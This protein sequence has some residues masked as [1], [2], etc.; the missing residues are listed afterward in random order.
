MRVR[1]CDDDE[2]MADGWVAAIKKVTDGYDVERMASA[3]E[4]ISK[5]LLRKMA[6]EKEQDLTEVACGFDDIDILAID[7]DLLHLDDDGSRT[8]GE[9]VA[10][11]ARTFSSCGV[12]VVMNQ[13]KGPQFDLGMRGHLDSH[14][15][16]NVDANLIDRPSLWHDLEP[17][18]GQFNPTT[19]T[20]LP[21]L[22]SAV[23]S[24]A[25]DFE[26]AGLDATVMDLLGLPEEALAEL[27][28]TAFGFVDSEAETTDQLAKVTVRRF[29]S[30][31]L[32]DEALV[33][34]FEA[35]SPK[36]LFSFAAF[37]IAK[38]LERA[39]L[40]PMDV[41]VD[42]LHL[43]DRLP[44]LINPAKI[45]TANPDSWYKAAADPAEFLHWD[46]LAKYRNERASACLGR[47]VFDWYRLAGD[48]Q[49]DQLQDAY[50]ASDA[51]R[52]FLAED[53]SRFVAREALTR[54]RADFHN[55]GDR[56]AVER[57]GNITYGPM[58]RVTFG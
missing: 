53:T 26:K 50:I 34:A 56:R 45:D 57:L 19:W 8:T 49:I 27:S 3:K 22:I 9:G 29:L 52:F 1:V 33:K 6:A 25:A 35:H 48:D 55:F 58:R 38:W 5:L 32:R 18:A 43:V 10:R 7:Y 12:I 44:F 36:T 15:D 30:Q 37:R 11:L 24:L 51:V 23:R 28:D 46:I 40:R 42:G 16:L 39:V 21:I 13:F 54:F 14:A 4:E 2:A 47:A 41:I 31:A 17:A 20:P